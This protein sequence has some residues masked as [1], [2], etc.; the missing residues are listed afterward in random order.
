MRYYIEITDYKGENKI[1]GEHY[2]DHEMSEKELQEAIIEFAEEQG[3]CP[4][5]AL[6]NC[7]YKIQ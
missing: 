3:V 6:A 5:M 4:S 2:S 7:K 1:A